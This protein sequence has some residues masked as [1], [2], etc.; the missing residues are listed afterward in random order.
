MPAPGLVHRGR[1]TE[2]ATPRVRRSSPP[3][4]D[5]PA[6]TAADG[7]ARTPR[8][9][10]ARGAHLL[11]VLTRYESDIPGVHFDHRAVFVAA[12]RHE[13]VGDT[14]RKRICAALHQL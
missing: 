3:W 14:A 8:S 5:R 4:R 1:N 10:H 9:R 2:C 6:P 11:V 12:H 13:R 7:T